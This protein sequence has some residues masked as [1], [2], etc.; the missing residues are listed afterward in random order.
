MFST[1]CFLPRESRR[2]LWT[3]F[4]LP[5]TFD[6]EL[7]TTTDEK[8]DLFRFLV[9][10]SGIMLPTSV[11]F[12]PIETLLTPPNLGASKSLET[13]GGIRYSPSISAALTKGSSFIYSLP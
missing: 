1:R 7:R 4:P 9:H 3:D 13:R 8:Q 2:R 12:I 5:L 11:I 10:V 6:H